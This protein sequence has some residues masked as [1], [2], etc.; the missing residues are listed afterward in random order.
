MTGLLIWLIGFLF[1]IGFCEH[2]TKK[3]GWKEEMVILVMWP[4]FWGSVFYDHLE[5]EEKEKEAT[6]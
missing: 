5:D 3:L 4:M 1:T 6:P 2:T